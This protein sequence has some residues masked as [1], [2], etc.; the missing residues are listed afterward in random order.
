MFWMMNH[1]GPHG[2]RRMHH[3]GFRPMGGL[4]L[5]P[6]ILFGGLFGLY[7]I[8]AVLNIAGVV[9]GTVFTGIGAALAWAVRGFGSLFTGLA[10]GGAFAASVAVGAALYFIIRRLKNGQAHTEEE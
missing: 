3:G 1:M 8:L 2:C 4:F 9:I 5:F 7:A 6:G 10:S